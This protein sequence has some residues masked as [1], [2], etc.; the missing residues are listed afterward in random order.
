VRPS[1]W[2]AAD[3]DRAETS[4]PDRVAGSG[5]YSCGDLEIEDISTCQ[6]LISDDYALRP[7]YT[8][9]SLDHT[10]S[11]LS[12]NHPNGE[13]RICGVRDSDRRLVG[14]FA[15]HT[16]WH[17]QLVVLALVALRGFQSV[18]LNLL[19]EDARQ[20]REKHMIVG[21]LQPHLFDSISERNDIVLR[22]RRFGM[23]IH[24]RTK[25]ILDDIHRGRGYFSPLDGEFPLT[26]SG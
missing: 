18:V 10:F 8:T 2:R 12:Q 21:W 3:R 5:S 14:W 22:P 16:C 26:F 9:A 24:S 1:R 7:K 6:H 15:W 23:V 13:V 20:R 19:I 11:L 4:L 25:S 17:G